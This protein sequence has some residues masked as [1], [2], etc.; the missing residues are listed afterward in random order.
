MD[1]SLPGSSAQEIIQARVLEWGAIDIQQI[2][3][4]LRAFVFPFPSSLRYWQCLLLLFPFRSWLICHLIIENF[5][6]YLEFN[7]ITTTL[8]IVKIQTMKTLL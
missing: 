2:Q 5:L 1:C 3:T 4:C 6:D 7:S 8:D